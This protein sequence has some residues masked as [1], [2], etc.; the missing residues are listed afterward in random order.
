[1]DVE[2][3]SAA[4][5]PTGPGDALAVVVFEGG[6]LSPQAEALDAGSGLLRQALG[7]RFTGVRGAL[8]L[9]ACSAAAGAAVILI[10][11]GRESDWNQRAAERAGAEALRAAE[12]FGARRL[13]LDFPRGD[14][15]LAALAAFGAALAGYRF[16]RHRTVLD[17]AKSASLAR[18]ETVFED[19]AAVRSAFAPLDALREG[20]FFARDL[21]SEPANVLGP[22]EFGDRLL[23]LES[24]GLSV[25]VLA[26][27]ELRSLGMDALIGVGAGSAAGTRLAV[28]RWAGAD[29]PEAAPLA[30]IGKGVT[31]DTGGVSIKPAAGLEEMKWDM[32]GAGAIAGAMVALARRRA[33]AN[34]V[35]VLALAENMVDGA[36]QRPGDIVRS[37]S[38]QTI[39]VVDTDAEGRL[40][41]ADALWYARTRFKPRA[42]IDLATLTGAV[43]VALGQDYGGLFCEDDELADAL[44]SAGRSCGEPLWRL[45]MPESYDR[46][47]ETPWADVRNVALGIGRQGGASIAARF[48]RRFAGD[49][50]WAHLDISAP[51]WDTRAPGLAS[52]PGVNAFGVRL[53][54]EL[55]RRSFEP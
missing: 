46:H 34:V 21:I 5:P 40:V 28:M 50:P 13:I 53:L 24:P 27:D 11:A 18:V 42:M 25:E 55:V 35:A 44:L 17:A 43:M 15:A 4:G 47:I 48:L 51:V 38:G 9:P 12:A 49:G 54:D 3:L 7:G 33:R 52:G 39:E 14:P 23:S 2:F 26:E 19:V 10:G 41:L 8:T 36:S 29:D 30:L 22:V 32:G 37:M 45:P 16:E 20:V 6:V 31:F 1:M